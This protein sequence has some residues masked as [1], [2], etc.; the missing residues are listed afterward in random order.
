MVRVFK[1]FIPTG[2]LILLFTETVVLL[3]C[4]LLAAQVAYGSG[5]MEYFYV[6]QNGIARLILAIFMVLS[7]LFLSNLY[8]DVR[9]D[10]RISLLLQLFVIFGCCFLAQALLDYMNPNWILPRWMMIWGSMLSIAAIFWLRVVFTEA[11][12]NSYGFQ[13]FLFVG[14]SPATVQLAQFFASH[15]ELGLLPVGYVDDPDS[16]EPP[17]TALR[18]LGTAADLDSILQTEQ[19]NCIAVGTRNARTVS[20][21]QLLDL[22]Y[23]GLMVEDIP[24]LYEIAFGKVCLSEVPLSDL[25]FQE[26]FH[27]GRRGL[28]AGT[29]VS[30]V[31]AALLLLLTLPLTLA[32]AAA[33]LVR[34]GGPVFEK[35][36]RIGFN[37]QPFD[38][39]DFCLPE[40]LAATGR[41]LRSSRIR[42]LPRLLNILRGE[43]AFVGPRPERQQYVAALQ[44]LLPFYSRRHAVLPG[45]ASWAELN[46]AGK[47]SPKNA[48]ETLEY[49]L[50]YI[51]NASVAFDTYILLHSLKP[52]FNS[53]MRS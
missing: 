12:R 24:H 18:C 5:E 33:I 25:L 43:M 44:Q 7:G 29:P 3:C 31:G 1:V 51:K 49:D 22:R 8:G 42:F 19:P 13:R 35:R 23:S 10:Q 36:R 47:G 20:T 32:V 37:Q 28:Q 53:S 52:L 4:Y 30:I 40:K 27:A 48:L 38:M 15:P 39:I 6:E 26:N 50:Y 17:P 21:E 41:W 9:V 34:T 45:L 11:T 2:T 46:V 16:V 14:L